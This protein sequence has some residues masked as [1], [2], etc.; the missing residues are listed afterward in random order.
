MLLINHKWNQSSLR[1]TFSI[2]LSLSPCLSLSLSL[3]F[4]VV[5]C[6]QFVNGSADGAHFPIEM[7]MKRLS[8]MLM[9]MLNANVKCSLSP[10]GSKHCQQSFHVHF[11]F[12]CVPESLSRI[13]WVSFILHLVSRTISVWH[14][15]SKR[16]RSSAHIRTHSKCISP[17][18]LRAAFVVVVVDQLLA[19]SIL[20][21]FHCVKDVTSA[22]ACTFVW[23]ILLKLSVYESILLYI[24][25]IT[26]AMAAPCDADWNAQIGT[27]ARFPH[28]ERDICHWMDRIQ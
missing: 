20:I 23:L 19:E 26:M 12:I 5:V 17:A 10:Y 22:I 28:D 6:L 24:R 25:R 9:L 18:M 2:I 27:N 21:M 3:S 11:P 16:S 13:E 7:K 4:G 1:C 15:D 8:L 14:I